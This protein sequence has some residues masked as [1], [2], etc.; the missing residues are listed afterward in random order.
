MGSAQTTEGLT[1]SYA[2]WRSSRLGQ[3]TDRLEQ[4]L[5]CELVGLV[6]DRRLLDVGCGDGALAA[7][8]ARLGAVVTGLDADPEMIAAARRRTE[9]EGTQLRLVEGRAESLPFSDATF[10]LVLAV[11]TLCFVRDAETVVMEMTRV[12][13]PGGRLVIGELGR[14]SFWAALRRIRG[15]LG[16]PTWRVAVFRTATEL[17][18]LLVA[19][20][21]DEV[22][23][24]GAAHYPPCG[25]AAQCFAPFDLWLGRQTT[26]GSAF[27]AVKAIKPFRDT[28]G[29]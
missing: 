6:A 26:L 2:R 3:I 14:R 17:Q 12:L 24:R 25:F 18:R 13:K 28:W 7:E 1:A 8:F 11:T 9:I 4:Q 22:E 27:I 10:D 16:D 15:W 5:L 20:R 29:K 21:L 19:A 23:T